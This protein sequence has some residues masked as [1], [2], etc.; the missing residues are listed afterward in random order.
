LGWRGVIHEAKSSRAAAIPMLARKLVAAGM[1]DVPWQAVGR[2][3]PVPAP[4]VVDTSP[5]RWMVDA[6]DGISV[7]PSREKRR[8]AT[9][10]NL[11]LGALL[12]G[13]LLTGAALQSASAEPATDPQKRVQQF[14]VLA[15]KGDGGAITRELLSLA[16]GELRPKLEGI[17]A[18]IFKNNLQGK[19]AKYGSVISETRLGDAIYRSI[20]AVDYDDSFFLFYLVDF[21]R[22]SGDGWELVNLTGG[23]NLNELLTKPWVFTPVQHPRRHR[24]AVPELHLA[25]HPPQRHAAW[26]TAIA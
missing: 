8:W 21:R 18:P 9:M 24:T 15:G 26:R 6:V 20:L 12:L 10:P 5:P 22:L 16:A 7:Y 1:A 11:S 23:T 14:A 19:N 13:C 3:A 17:L 25:H 4:C 2:L